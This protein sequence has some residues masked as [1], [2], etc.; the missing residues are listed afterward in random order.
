MLLKNSHLAAILETR[1]VRRSVAQASAGF[2]P[3][4][5]I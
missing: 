5:T 3:G 1:L 2:S 4:A